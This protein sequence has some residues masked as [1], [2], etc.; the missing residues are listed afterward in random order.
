MVRSKTFK[1]MK[2]PKVTVLMSVYNGEKYLR[3][4]VDSILAQTF[5]DFEFIIINDGSTDKTAEILKSYK[6]ARI[7]IVNN[8]KNIGL[9]KSLNKG[10]KMAR[11]K[12]IARQDADDIS[13]PKRLETQVRYLEEHK[14]I[15]A[16]GTCINRIDDYGE[17]IGSFIFPI[18]P[19]D[20]RLNLLFGRWVFA[21]GS[22]MFCN[23]TINPIRYDENVLYAQDYDLWLKLSRK[24]SMANIKELLYNLRIYDSRI[25]AKQRS[26]QQKNVI[27]SLQNELENLLGFRV[28]KE[29]IMTMLLQSTF[30]TREYFIKAINLV[31]AIKKWFRATVKLSEDA[32]LILINK[33]ISEIL[34]KIIYRYGRNFFFL[35]LSYLIRF[36][37]YSYKF[38]LSKGTFKFLLN[39]N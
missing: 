17:T 24:F 10:L 36:S 8:D 11:G 38:I 39:L 9:T 28:S 3:E 14:S 6:D 13:F 26:I 7:K 22:I 31:I 18:S 5:K 2:K 23:S 20:I 37:K 25:A 29:V 16:V 21:H 19:I 15:I 4:A 12:Y 35:S 30:P 32:E 34:R 33:F 27:T 1:E